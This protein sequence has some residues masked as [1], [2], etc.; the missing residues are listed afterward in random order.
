VFGFTSGQG[1]DGRGR[2]WHKGRAVQTPDVGLQGAAQLAQLL[3]EEEAH[4]FVGVAHGLHQAVVAEPLEGPKFGPH[5]SIGPKGALDLG[6][7]LVEL[8]EETFP[9]PV[10]VVAALGQEILEPLHLSADRFGVYVGVELDVDRQGRRGR[11]SFGGAELLQGVDDPRQ[12]RTLVA[13]ICQTIEA[14]GRR[15]QAHQGVDVG[16]EVFLRIVARVDPD[17]AGDKKIGVDLEQVLFGLIEAVGHPDLQL[18]AV[19]DLE[20]DGDGQVPTPI[21][22][23]LVR[24]RSPL[25]FG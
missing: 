10:F 18:L 13:R 7:A 9:G 22:L 4:V 15:L 20:L 25:L 5:P 24:G 11:G 17:V 1:G 21:F 23:G 12:R 16:V 6:E 8:R 14:Q 3:L 19:V 2:P